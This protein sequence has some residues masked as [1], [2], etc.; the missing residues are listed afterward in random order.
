MSTHAQL[1][2]AGR[3]PVSDCRPCPLPHLPAASLSVLLSETRHLRTFSKCSVWKHNQWGANQEL[4]L[5][6]E[7][8][9]Y[10]GRK[11]VSL[12]RHSPTWPGP[13]LNSVTHKG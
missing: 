8:A 10:S 2:G 13:G 4:C 12:I 1:G 3:R 5:H 9:R 7:Q 6:C 11:W